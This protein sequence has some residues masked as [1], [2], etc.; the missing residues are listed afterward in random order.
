MAGL[1]KWQQPLAERAEQADARIRQAMHA[2][3]GGSGALAAVA[4]GDRELAELCLEV[5]ERTA[6]PLLRQLL[7]HGARALA[8]VAHDLESTVWAH[9]D[10]APVPDTAVPSDEEYLQGADE[11]VDVDEDQAD[12]PSGDLVDEVTAVERELG[13]TEPE[14]RPQQP[15]VEEL[16][17]TYLTARS[18]FQAAMVSEGF[19]DAA[20]SRAVAE[21]ADAVAAALRRARDSGHYQ[22]IALW[23]L[24]DACMY[25]KRIAEEA[26]W[27]GDPAPGGTP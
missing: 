8:A 5:A 27:R 10:H 16:D 22:G 11:P 4:T 20:A 12:E 25:Y 3:G 13:E 1:P 21:A 14:P 23:A 26:R 9:T 18:A 6:S 15:A 2:P 19:G 17:E 24:E 7:Q